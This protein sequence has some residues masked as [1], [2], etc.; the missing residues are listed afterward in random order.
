MPAAETLPAF[1]LWADLG[2]FVR[3]V[4]QSLEH[5]RANWRRI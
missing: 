3:E 2:D 5:H 1:F 4:M